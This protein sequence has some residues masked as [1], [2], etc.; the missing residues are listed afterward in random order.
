MQQKKSSHLIIGDKIYQRNEYGVNYP[1]ISKGLFKKYSRNTKK[2]REIKCLVRGEDIESQL[3][4]SV[5]FS[6]Q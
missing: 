1:I 3:I 2:K 6:L 5:E 4:S